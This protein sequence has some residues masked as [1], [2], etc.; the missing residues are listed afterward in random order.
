MLLVLPISARLFVSVLL[1]G[2]AVSLNVSAGGGYFALGYGPV[3]R[4]T[5]GAVTAVAEDAFAGASN[6]AK[7]SYA[8]NR[9][10]VGLELFNPHRK[11]KRTGATGSG[12]IYNFS[13]KSSNS[14]FFIPEFAYSR[15]VSEKLAIGLT[16][17]AN[18]GL[19]SEYHG[20]TEISGTSGNPSV[21]GAKPGNF[22][23]GCGQL[24]FD[25]S[26]LIIAPTVAWQIGPGQSI[27][28]SPLIVIQRFKAFGFQAFAPLSQFPSRASNNGYDH[29]FGGGVRVGWYGE[30]KPWLSLGAA[31]S[32]KVYMQDFDKYKGLFAEGSFDIPANYNIGVAIKPHSDWRI[33]IDIQRIEFGEVRSLRNS[34]LNS[35]ISSDRPLGSDSGSGF[36]WRRNQTNYRLGLSYRV[37][38]ELTVRAG[39]AYGKRPNDNNIN[40]VS[41]SVLT[42]NSIRQASAGFTWKTARGNE[43]HMAISRFLLST[44]RGP[45]AL[46]PG[47]T[48]SLSPYVNTLSAAWSQRF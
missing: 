38:P 47:A 43:F 35:L 13:T 18:G 25:L 44:Y 8:G 2:L 19:N 40:A 7:L 22:L 29:A 26:Q 31:Y 21:C 36:G 16:A 33:A 23:L 41:L 37:T 5:S 27:G 14:L 46:F 45:S 11:I 42:P 30:F 32:S 9:L 48:E 1:F 12:E 3:G 6:P 15:Q 39:F 24:G 34:V 20:T 17:Y 4:Q 28:V 10:E